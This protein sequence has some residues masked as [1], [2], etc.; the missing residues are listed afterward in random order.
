[1]EQVSLLMRFIENYFQIREGFLPTLLVIQLLEV[2]ITPFTLGIDS[3]FRTAL[4]LLLP[5]VVAALLLG[6][7]L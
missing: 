3:L 5:G 1:M 2:F 4:F 6:I 7:H